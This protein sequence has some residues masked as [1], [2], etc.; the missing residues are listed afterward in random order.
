MT[1]AHPKVY[2]PNAKQRP[3]NYCGIK[4]QFHAVVEVVSAKAWIAA[5]ARMQAIGKAR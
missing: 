1:D 3:A 2:E 5:I 4:H